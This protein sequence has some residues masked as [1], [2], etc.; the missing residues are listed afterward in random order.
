MYPTLKSKVGDKASKN[1][2]VTF[3]L[4]IAKNRG[5][6]RLPI[7]KECLSLVSEN[8]P[9]IVLPEREETGTQC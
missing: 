5:F 1:E 9:L 7:R 8:R 2:V 3:E 4:S 6:F